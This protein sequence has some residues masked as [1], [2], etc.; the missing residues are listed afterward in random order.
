MYNIFIRTRGG[1]GNQLFQAAAGLQLSKE[2]NNSPLDIIF[3]TKLHNRYLLK[4]NYNINDDRSFML[5]R[6]E[7]FKNKNFKRDVNIKF[8]DLIFKSKLPLLYYKFL[9]QYFKTHF[10][11]GKNFYLD[12]YFIKNSDFSN[13]FKYIKKF[14][15]QHLT[16]QPKYSCGVHV[17]AGDYL[18]TKQRQLCSKMYYKVCMGYMRQFHCIKKFMIYTENIN[19]ALKL[20]PEEYI[21]DCLFF[22]GSE[23]EDFINLCSHDFLISANSTFS[24]CAGAIGKSKCFIGTE[25]FYHYGDRPNRLSKE[26]IIPFN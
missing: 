25:Y 19:Y 11:L 5:D 1:L 10:K 20:I 23:E 24:W 14:M 4:K 13:E 2:L 21:D 8:S 18:L 9:Y 15:Y 22:S 16:S 12:G 17:R 3:Y 26:I 6:L 7:L